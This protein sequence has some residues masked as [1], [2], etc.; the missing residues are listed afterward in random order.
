MMLDIQHPFFLGCVTQ[1]I[2]MIFNIIIPLILKTEC[3]R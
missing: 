3:S 2:V 1:T